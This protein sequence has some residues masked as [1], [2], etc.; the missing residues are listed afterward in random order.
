MKLDVVKRRYVAF[1][2]EDRGRY[3]FHLLPVIC[4]LLSSFFSLALSAQGLS[5]QEIIQKMA[6]AAE[7]IKTVQCNFTQTKNLKMMSKEMVSKGKMYCQQPEKLR[8]EY[9]TPRQST[10]IL[11]GT[12]ARLTKDGAEDGTRNKFIGEMARMIMNSIAGKCLTD[13]K[14]FQ[15]TAKELPTEYVATLLPLRK[16]MKRLYTKLVLHFDIKQSTVTEVELYEK[17]GDR[18]VIE[19]HDIQIN[20]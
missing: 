16:E 10:L 14:S 20:K 15:V 7:K 1:S 9:T 19:L 8:W 17:N 6:S 3:I 5:E 2:D 13:S 18:T 12:H 4:L 11:D